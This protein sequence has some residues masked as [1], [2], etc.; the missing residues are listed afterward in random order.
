MKK[1]IIL[2]TIL[3]ILL[4]PINTFATRKIIIKNMNGITYKELTNRK[5]K[6]LIERDYGIVLDYKGNGKI[7]NYKYKGYDYIKYPK[8]F[9]KGDII[10]TYCVFNPDNNF[11]DDIIYRYDYKIGHTNKKVYWMNYRSFAKKY[12]IIVKRNT[13]KIYK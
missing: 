6:V 13:N 8:K 9:K 5:G 1:I 4:T 11:E 12:D 2:I 7:M 10:L 3:V